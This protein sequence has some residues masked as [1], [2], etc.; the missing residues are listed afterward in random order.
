M[1]TREYIMYHPFRLCD[2]GDHY[3]FK[4]G[5]LC[6]TFSISDYIGIGKFCLSAMRK[7]VA[8]Q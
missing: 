4:L 3:I 7:L 8:F 2:Q 6:F 1:H 5:A